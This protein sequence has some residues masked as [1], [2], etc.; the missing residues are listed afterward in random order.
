MIPE[1]YQRLAEHLDK[2]PA[3]YPGTP[4]GVELRILQRLFS[5]PE[6][7]LALHL[8][9]IAEEP[10][11]IASRAGISLSKTIQRLEEM[12]RKGLIFSIQVGS[13]LRYRI[14]QF[15]VGFWEGQVDK[16]NPNL[17]ADF[18]E[19]LESFVDLDLWQK[20]PQLRTLPVEKSIPVKANALPYERVEELVRAQE[21]LAINN[22][23]CRQERRIAG[24]GCKKPEESCLSFGRAAERSIR[25][26]KGR[27]ISRKEAMDILKVAEESGLVLQTSNSRETLFIC[28]CC[29]CCC[30]LLRSIKA[31]SDPASRVSSP[32]IVSLD[33]QACIGDGICLDRCQMEAISMNQDK[34]VINLKRCI[35]CGLCVSTC[36]TDALSLIR[37]P[38]AEQFHVPRTTTQ[39]YMKLGRISGRMKTRS[40]INMKLNSI[41]DRVKSPA[42]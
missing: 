13:V 29:G 37:K 6:A 33:I 3:G 15:I 7:E 11:V 12:D 4:S 20:M 30:G 16:L 2:L 22:C 18:E 41:I 25:L 23:I 21:I 40:F 8:T 19:Y 36:P 10:K 34:A 42:S 24:D 31:D 27:A 17:V 1:I 14:Q 38:P 35:G 28:T 26:G 39:T 5:V 32:F 9:L